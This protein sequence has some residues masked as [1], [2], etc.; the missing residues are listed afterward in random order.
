MKHTRNTAPVTCQ[1]RRNVDKYRIEWGGGVH[2]IFKISGHFH[3]LFF[4]MI[5]GGEGLRDV[6][7][8]WRRD[9]QLFVCLSLFEV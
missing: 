1:R 5:V 8:V 6:C 7:I 4:Y 2:F 3:A 9:L